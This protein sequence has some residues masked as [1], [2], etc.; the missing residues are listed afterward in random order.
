[1]FFSFFN[2]SSNTDRFS[3]FQYGSID[4]LSENL[5]SDCEFLTG[6]FLD[7]HDFDEDDDLFYLHALQ[8]L[9]TRYDCYYKDYLNLLS[10][11]PSISLLQGFRFQIADCRI[12]V[13]FVVDDYPKLRDAFNQYAFGSDG[14]NL[15]EQLELTKTNLLRL[16]DEISELTSK[17][18]KTTPH[19]LK[20][21]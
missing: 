2:H 16:N 13:P 14:W 21:K 3:S 20:Q 1:M 17:N 6:T 12:E 15:P 11:S 10:K 4:D 8:R 18:I 9:S 5:I 19:I 7:D